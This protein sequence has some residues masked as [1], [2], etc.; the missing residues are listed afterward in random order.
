MT[1]LERFSDRVTALRRR[2][3]KL[4]ENFDLCEA[5]WLHLPEEEQKNYM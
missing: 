3:Q 5:E 2:Y 4:E 1:S